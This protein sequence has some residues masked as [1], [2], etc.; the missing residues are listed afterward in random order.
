LFASA[1][2]ALVHQT[3]HNPRWSQEKH[4]GEP[5]GGRSHTGRGGR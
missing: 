5:R 4:D 2:Q 3:R 1:F